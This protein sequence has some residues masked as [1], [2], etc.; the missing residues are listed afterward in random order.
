MSSLTING[1]PVD[2]VD[3]HKVLGLEINSSLKW[4]DHV[5]TITKKAAKRLHSI[6]VLRQSGLS[7][8][9]LISIYIALIRSILEYC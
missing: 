5:D 3:S 9:E 8:D 4:S 2:I 7:S 1:T 6:R